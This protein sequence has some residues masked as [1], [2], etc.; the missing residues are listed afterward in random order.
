MRDIAASREET[1][2]VGD[3]GSIEVVG[4]RDDR[5]AKL[6]A[7]IQGEIGAFTG[8]AASATPDST[9]PSSRS[10]A[11]SSSPERSAMPVVGVR[12]RPDHPAQA[13][14]PLTGKQSIMKTGDR[15]TVALSH[16]AG[17][18]ADIRPL[19]VKHG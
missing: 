19:L 3:K 16:E 17:C 12:S 10:D 9:S 6:G 15:H 18:S 1:G 8:A 14:Q 13:A 11:S 4:A 7:L 2:L 5:S